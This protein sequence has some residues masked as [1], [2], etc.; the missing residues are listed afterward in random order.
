MKAKFISNNN[1]SVRMFE[2]PIL[3]YFSHIHPATPAVV[4]LPVVGWG[5][6]SAINMTTWGPTILWGIGGVLLW[7]LFEYLIHRFLFHIE[8]KTDL[9]KRVHFLVHGVHH[10]YPR[11]AS[12]LVM[13]LLLSAPLAIL[14]YVAFHAIVAPYHQALFAGFVLGYVAYD[15]IHFATHHWHFKGRVGRFLKEYHMKHHYVDEHTAYGV[16]TPLWDVLLGTLP[17][18]LHKRK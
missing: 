10:D 17:Q 15:S 12:R 11:D 16:S 8:P 6:W 1:E 7:T 2:N 5:V 9:G 18:W 13:P 4:Y 3:E 14:F